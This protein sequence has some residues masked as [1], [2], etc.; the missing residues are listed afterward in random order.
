M[1]QRF[2]QTSQS[3]P[4]RTHSTICTQSR[5]REDF[6]GRKT[7]DPSIPI[8]QD[9]RAISNTPSKTFLRKITAKQKT[10]PQERTRGSSCNMQEIIIREIIVFQ[11][12]SSQ[13]LWIFN[14]VPTLFSQQG[15]IKNLQVSKT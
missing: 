7:G 8:N 11:H 3:R 13:G 15:L 12:T 14:H 10:T 5:W 2:I 9:R 4:K 1:N 6:E